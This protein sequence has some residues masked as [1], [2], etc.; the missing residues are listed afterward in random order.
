MVCVTC[1]EF[2]EKQNGVSYSSLDDKSASHTNGVA[3]LNGTSH[4]NG[5]GSQMKEDVV[6]SSQAVYENVDDI[7]A[8]IR[9]LVLTTR[10]RVSK[11]MYTVHCR[12]VLNR[13]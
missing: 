6:P 5:V 4:T 9:H 2:F 8:R 3:H 11:I 7:L 10:R 1:P 12:N 13:C